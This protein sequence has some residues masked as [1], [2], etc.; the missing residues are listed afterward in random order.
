MG[1][2]EL[3]C[4]RRQRNAKQM[5]VKAGSLAVGEEREVVSSARGTLKWEQWMGVRNFSL[6]AE[7]QES[8]LGDAGCLWGE[9]EGAVAKEHVLREECQG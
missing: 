4:R 9:Q 7:V 6:E 8:P 3:R 5:S 1:H 2:Q